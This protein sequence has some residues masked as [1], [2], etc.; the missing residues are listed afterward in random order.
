MEAVCRSIGLSIQGY[1]GKQRPVADV[2][3][4]VTIGRFRGRMLQ[5]VSRDA[6]LWGMHMER[7]EGTWA[8]VRD[9]C[10]SR[11]GSP[12]RVTVLS[13]KSEGAVVRVEFEVEDGRGVAL[14]QCSECPAFF[15]ASRGNATTCSDRC[16]QRRHRRNGNPTTTKET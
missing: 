5:V 7:R 12:C 13:Q 14:V 2:T 9:A 15:E 1:E 16:R 6:I 10:N 3:S 11:E 8:M 4:E